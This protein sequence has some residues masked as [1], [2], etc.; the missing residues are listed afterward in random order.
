[1]RDED[2]PP[3]EPPSVYLAL[4]AQVQRSSDQV[5]LTFEGS[6]YTYSELLERVDAAA[7]FL[8]SRGVGVG[9]GDRVAAFGQN[10]PEI[11]FLFYATARLGAVFVPLNPNLSEPELEYTM[12]NSGASLLFHDDRVRDVAVAAVSASSRVE[13][14][15]LAASGVDEATLPAPVIGGDFLI[16]YTSGTTGTPKAIVLDQ[17]GVV[18]G[19]QALS[20][21]WKIGPEDVVLVALPLGYLYGLV[22]A[23]ATTLQAGGTV[24]L[25]R[26]FHPKYVLED[27]ITSEATVFQGVPTMYSM[28]LAY[29]EEQGLTFDLS[30]LRRTISAGAPLSTEMRRRFGERFGTEPEDYFAMTE[31]T[32][33]F[34]CFGSDDQLPAGA[35]GRLAPAARVRIVRP[36]DSDCEDGEQGEL[37]IRAGMMMNRYWNSPELTERSV[38]NGYFRSGDLGRRDSDG[39]FYLTG[40]IKDIIIRGGANISPAEVEVALAEHPAIQ[41]VAVLG[42]A[43]RIFGEVPIAVVVLRASEVTTAE[44]VIAF[45]DT[46][47]AD[48][49]VPRHIVFKSELPIGKTGK[50]DKAALLKQLA[51]EDVAA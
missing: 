21:M 3:T 47:L 19:C 10:C 6:H 46:R 34:G 36:D 13:F 16:I 42:I 22:T 17:A 28:M 9:V 32:P 44:D 48:F 43:D 50:V 51:S 35:I 4:C 30:G 23:S 27:L 7:E 18:S 38:V 33:V 20:E 39:F 15:Q 11:L 29:S 41:S 31:A 5:A 45:A 26:R 40:R 25:L 1:M 49:K 2:V 24:A 37:L 8:V 14:S 12:E